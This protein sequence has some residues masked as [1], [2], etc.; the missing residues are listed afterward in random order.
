MPARKIV[1]TPLTH[2]DHRAIL[3]RFNKDEID[4]KQKCQEIGARFTK[5]HKGWWIPRSKDDVNMLYEAFE[6]LAYVD[7]SAFKKQ[8]DTAEQPAEKR[9]NT[10]IKTSNRLSE[11]QNKALALMKEK[12]LVRRY[13]QSTLNTYTIMFRGFMLYFEATDPKDISEAQI[14]A[15]MSHLVREKKVVQST[16][17]QN[18]NAIKFYYEH[19]LGLEKK[20][21]WLERPRKEHKLPKVLSEND[22]VRLITAT[23]NLKHQ[24]I[25]SILYSTGMRRGEIVNIRLQDIDFDRRQIRINGGK[26]KKDRV[27]LLSEHMSSGLQHYIDQYNPKYWLIENVNRTKYSDNSVGKVVRDL[28]RKAG[29]KDVTP[30][31]LRH[32]FATHLM[33]NGTDLRIIQSLLGHESIETTQIY[34]HVSNK[35]LAGIVNPLDRIINE[36]SNAA[37]ILDDGREKK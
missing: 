17:N 15:Y 30:H 25:V 35:N 37:M 22:I 31:V 5:T 20:K 18:I 12:L 27:T 16:H 8:S 34:T 2:R 3:I 14:K 21:Y 10:A 11:A 19:V 7:Y 33:D 1:L 6:P 23:K 26:G 28:S 24:I 32:S 36:K 9:A 4:L 13:S 29:H